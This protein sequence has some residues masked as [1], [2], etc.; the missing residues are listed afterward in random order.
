MAVGIKS[1]EF[2]CYMIVIIDIIGGMIFYG[3]IFLSV[4][5]KISMFGLR[6]PYAFETVVGFESR[7]FAGGSK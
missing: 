3:H 1:E 5:T 6:T 7:D 4:T 2:A